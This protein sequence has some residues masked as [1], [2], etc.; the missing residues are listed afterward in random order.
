M[1]SIW[2][3]YIQT[4][5]VLY[6]T[7]KLRFD[8]RFSVEYKNAFCIGENSKILEI[9]CGPGA[10]AQALYRWYPD[11]NMVATDRD[12]GLLKFASEKAPY[13]N[14]EEADAVALPFEESTFDVTISNTV[15]EHVVPEK[16]FGEQYRVLK[17]GGV[18]IVL[19]S[20]RGI[21]HFSDTVSSMSDFENE[22]WQKVEKY[23]TE[24]DEK[25]SVCQYPLSE[26]ELPETMM[27][28]GF[29]N[30]STDYITVNL[31]PDSYNTDDGFAIEIIE[32]NRQ[33]NLEWV[34][35]LPHIAP[36]V[37]SDT[38]IEKLKNVI[39]QKYDRRILQYKNGNKQWDTNVNIIMVVRGTKF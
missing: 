28:Y 8:D 31:T 14:F 29:K 15:Q 25:F 6:R 21:N 27:K 26:K 11:C 24:A 1:N 20:R 10:L 17:P 36:G 22:M 5:E 3:T 16:F 35:R 39:N 34:L 37:V 12:N 18:C 32:T 7:R 13:I 33:S 30:V 38:E 9:G 19:S 4:A 23:Y 2:S